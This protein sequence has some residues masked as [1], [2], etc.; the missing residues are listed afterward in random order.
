MRIAING[1][2]RIGRGFFRTAFGQPDVEIVAINDLADI[3]NL[4]YL[5]RYDTVYG[6][7]G[8]E[9]KAEKE[10]G[11]LLIDGKPVKFLQEKELLKLPWKDLNVD[12]VIESTGVFSTIDKVVLHLDAGAKRVVLSAPFKK[13]KMDGVKIDG[14]TSLAINPEHSRR[15]EGVTVLPGINDDDLSKSPVSSNGSCT[16]NAV[17][18]IV[19]ILSQNP[20]IK[21][22]LLNTI[23]A[24]TATQKIV[25]GP[26]AKDWRRG[27]AGAVSLIPSTTGAAIS[28]TEIIPQMSG[29][30]DGICVR[31]PVPVVSLAD[32][33][34]ISSR[35]TTKEEINEILRYESTKPR[36]EKIVKVSDEPLVSADLI[37][38]PYPSVIDAEFTKVVD[39]DLVKILAWYDNEWG[40]NQSLLYH[41]RKAATYIRK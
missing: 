23:H 39:G 32:I 20:G 3:D 40:Y 5:L 30:F 38:D 6:R 26:D 9:V 4:A 27:R 14:S 35:P 19:Y 29:L 15:I 12:V 31:A 24:Y 16:T 18:P 11:F 34:F 1:F 21:K 7:Y 25:D 13:S 22:A 36:W 8:H 37:A 33:T 41:I 17:A 10:K 2:G 28:V